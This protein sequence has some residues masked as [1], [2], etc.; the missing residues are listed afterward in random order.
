M[1]L[2]YLKVM[3][4]YN[5]SE[6]ELPTD[7]IN[8][9]SAIKSAMRLAK[10]RELKRQDAT[11]YYEKAQS[12]D[13]FVVKEI[14]DLIN[15]TEENGDMPDTDFVDEELDEDSV[16][17]YEQDEDE[18]QEEYK[19]KG[20]GIKINSELAELYKNGK[21]EIEINELKNLAPNCYETI[22]DCY[23]ANGENG[24][25]TNDYNLIEYEKQKYKLTKS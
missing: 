6:R 5:L 11:Q 15:N 18:E 16:N 10:L 19:P 1:E 7:A 12:F 24:I 17:E 20:D 13:R 22:F 2:E 23:E 3:E 4:E 14:Q 25:Q 8:A 9:I 21:T